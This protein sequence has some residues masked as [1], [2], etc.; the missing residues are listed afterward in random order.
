MVELAAKPCVTVMIPMAHAADAQRS[1]AFYGLLGME[2]RGNLRNASGAL[3]WIHI[4]CAQAELMLTRA[5]AP[6][7][8]ISKRCCSISTRPI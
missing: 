8:H 3:Q 5:S 6:V 4:G 1:V 7:S 2:T